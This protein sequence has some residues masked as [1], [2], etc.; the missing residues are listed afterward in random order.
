MQAEASF[1]NVPCLICRD[2]TERPVYCKH[3]TSQLVWRDSDKV[4]AALQL[5]RNGAYQTSE[6]VVK[7]LGT[8][9]AKKTVRITADYLAG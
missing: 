2:T 3:G 6:E 4:Q 5:I 9:V 1:F 8:D 7:E